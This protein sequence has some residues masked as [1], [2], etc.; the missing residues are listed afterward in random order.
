MSEGVHGGLAEGQRVVLAKTLDILADA[1]C[2]Y[3]L[4]EQDP[5]VAITALRKAYRDDEI[6][7]RLK[8]LERAIQDSD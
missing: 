5:A 7:E 8:G 6:W 2:F 3:I 4:T 1:L